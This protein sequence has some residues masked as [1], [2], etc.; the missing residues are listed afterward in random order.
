MTAD[1]T[2]EIRRLKAGI[3][4]L[5]E[6]LK[7]YEQSTIRQTRKLELQQEM[8]IKSHEELEHRVV[9]RTA[10]LARSNAD[11]EEFAHIVA[12]DL[13]APLRG[14][15]TL[16]NW[17]VSDYADKLD[18]GG[19]Q[20]I[21]LLISRVKRMGDLIDG[22]LRYSVVGRLH[23]EKTAVHLNSLVAEVIDLLQPPPPIEI[24]VEGDLPILLGNAT[25]LREL[26]QNLIG[27]GIK[28]MDK[29]EGRIAI[30]CQE[31][32]PYW[33]FYVSD[34]GPGIEERYFEK[35]FQMFQTLVPRDQSESTGVGLTVAKK[36][37]E[38][39]GG[40]IWVESQV[41]K[42]STFFF[43]LPKEG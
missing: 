6:L 2:V 23:P 18:E 10:D 30:G 9:E 20:Q 34:N 27:N 21:G 41:G 1:E 22:I 35:I 25:R 42:G 11:L 7:V 17:L 14:I 4:V 33:K 3:S 26:F 8:L 29:P 12:H 40:R 31:D 28:F 15:A 36:I 43:T 38:R 39:A 24:R 19:K 16:G 5:E 13:K 32:A 37:V